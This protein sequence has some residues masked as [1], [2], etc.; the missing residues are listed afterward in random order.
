MKYYINIYPYSLYTDYKIEPDKILVLLQACERKD[1]HEFATNIIRNYSPQFNL[2]ST[3]YNN[4]A[5]EHCFELTFDNYVWNLKVY[6][7]DKLLVDGE[8]LR[9]D[10]VH[11]VLVGK[12]V[13]FHYNGGS[14]YGAKRCVRI[15]EVHDNHL[16][17]EDLEKKA[18]RNFKISRI[19]G[20]LGGITPVL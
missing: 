3:I 19:R 15:T 1:V 18:V 17:C 9:L 12:I 4:D 2:T 14:K 11:N 13:T 7:K 16:I 5:A 8:L 10:T 20:G 6:Y